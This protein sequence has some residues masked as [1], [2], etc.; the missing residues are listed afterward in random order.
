MRLSHFLFPIPYLLLT[1]HQSTLSAQQKPN[2]IIIYADDLGYGD[3]SCYGMKRIQTPNIDRLAKSGIRFTN[4]HSTSATC[5]PSRFALMTGTYPWRKTGTGVAPGDASLIIPTD[6]ATTPSVLKKAGYTTAVIGKWHLGLGGEKGPNWNGD[7]KPGPN[8]VGFD[9]SFIMPA[10]LDRVPTVYVENH[11]I[12]HLQSDDPITVSYKEKVGTWPTGKEN[13]EKLRYKPSPNHGHDGTITDSISRIGWMTGGKAALWKDE[14]IAQTIT[15]KAVDFMGRSRKQPFFLY[16]ASGDIHVPRYPHKN[17]RGKSGMGLRGDA[18]LQLDWAVGELMRAI[19]S[20]GI[21][22]NTLVIFSSDNGPVVDDGYA[23]E[24]VAKLG[25]HKPA[26][27]LRGGKYSIFDAG[28]RVP[29]IVSW[30]G[31]IPAGKTSGA[32]VSQVDMLATL[33]TLSGQSVPKNNAADSFNQLDIWMGKKSNRM[34]LVEHAGTLSITR[35]NWK[36]IEPSKG[37]AYAPLTNTELGNNPLPQLYNLAKD[38]GEKQNLA[39]SNPQKV[40][41]L[42]DLLSNIKAQR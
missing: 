15:Q 24:A 5:T 6:K 31:K 23:D 37:R 36:Y 12:V 30:P 38:P 41:E 3:V 26:G 40:K 16:Y 14:D 1:T 8:E 22:R 25:N 13:P 11:K 4:A 21:A 20:L 19:D 2:I 33:A 7:I 35:E 17:F 9:Y 32:L 29:F 18:I 28:T 34:Y 27:P 39:A 10:T 42:A